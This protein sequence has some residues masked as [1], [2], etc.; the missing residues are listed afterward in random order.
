MRLFCA[1][2]QETQPL[3]PRPIISQDCSVSNIRTLR[4]R[5][6]VSDAGHHSIIRMK[7][8]RKLFESSRKM[9]KVFPAFCEGG[10]VNAPKACTDPPLST[11]LRWIPLRLREGR[12]SSAGRARGWGTRSERKADPSRFGAR[13]DSVGRGH[14]NSRGNGCRAEARRYV[15][16]KGRSLGQKLPS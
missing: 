15:K 4:L 9:R 6:S 1:V 10:T 13:D 14:P 7:L 3:F 5:G 8:V 12:A 11:T 16:G 2:N